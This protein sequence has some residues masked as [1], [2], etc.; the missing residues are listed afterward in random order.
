MS[1]QEIE[2]KRVIKIDW[3]EQCPKCQRSK[4]DVTTIKGNHE[5]LFDGDKVK[6]WCFQSGE[7]ETNDNMAWVE[8]D[9][10][11]M[12]DKD[13]HDSYYRKKYPDFWEQLPSCN[14]QA[15]EH[16]QLSLNS[17]LFAL[18]SEKEKLKTLEATPAHTVSLTCE[19]LLEA[20]LFGAPD[21]CITRTEYS[22]KQM[23]TEM[24]IVWLEGGHSGKGYYAYYTELPEEGSIHL[25]KFDYVEAD[26]EETPNDI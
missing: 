18:H 19:Q 26:K 5:I 12:T 13:H 8:W 15:C 17:W 3:L 7:I 9:E 10:V 20:L 23:D 22:E 21:L 11:V 16:Y 4:F 25:G 24:S 1:K 2:K 14:Y 6:C